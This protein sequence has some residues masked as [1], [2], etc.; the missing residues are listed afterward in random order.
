M[1]AIAVWLIV[2]IAYRF[3]HPALTETQ[4]FQNLLPVILTLIG[5]ILV[6]GWVLRQ[7]ED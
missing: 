2:I 5:C 6:L 4:L 1:A 7:S 3:D